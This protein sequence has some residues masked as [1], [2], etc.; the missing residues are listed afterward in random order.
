MNITSPGEPP[1]RVPGSKRPGKNKIKTRKKSRIDRLKGTV[2]SVYAPLRAQRLKGTVS[3][4]RLKGTVPSVYAPLRAQRLKGTVPL[5]RLKGTVPSVYAP[6]GAQPLIRAQHTPT[7][8]RPP[9]QDA[10]KD[11]AV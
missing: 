6:L 3:L 2:P 1:P 9:V 4:I 8:S 5:I 7:I 10:L 11:N